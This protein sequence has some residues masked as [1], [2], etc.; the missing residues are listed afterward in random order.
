LRAALRPKARAQFNR[1]AG[2]QFEREGVVA[3]DFGD[4]PLSVDLPGGLTA[5][6]AVV[7]RGAS[8]A[9]RALPTPDAA[10][11]AHRR[12]VRRLYLIELGAE[13]REMLNWVPGL[14]ELER[15]HAPLGT[16]AELHDAL[17]GLTVEHA[18]L[19]GREAPRT[20]QAFRA[21][22]NAARD[23]LWTHAE[24]VCGLVERILQVLAEV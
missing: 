10:A 4:L 6:P 14:A 3:W 22:L 17:L 13:L 12:G 15:L 8:V 11:A 21:A 7:D 1:L 24:V 23:D 20:E 9:L 5:W 2:A 18:L 16:D 19:A